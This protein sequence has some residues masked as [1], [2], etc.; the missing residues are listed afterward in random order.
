[1]TTQTNTT[2][3][4]PIQIKH[5]SERKENHQLFHKMIKMSICDIVSPVTQQSNRKAV[6]SSATQFNLFI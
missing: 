4:I 2:N 5:S 3:Q 6:S 1:M